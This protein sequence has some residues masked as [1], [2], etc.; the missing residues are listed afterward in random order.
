MLDLNHLDARILAE[1]LLV[2][3][4]D[5][6][7]REHENRFYVSHRVWSFG[8]RPGT[9]RPSVSGNQRVVVVA[10]QA[11]RSRGNIHCIGPQFWTW[12]ATPID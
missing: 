6:T 2:L 9:L 10:F 12:S 5:W 3:F 11:L 1:L 4:W 8:T 7:A